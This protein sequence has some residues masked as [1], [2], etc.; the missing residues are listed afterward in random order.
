MYKPENS[1][2]VNAKDGIFFLQKTSNNDYLA[3]F[4]FSAANV[5][6]FQTDEIDNFRLGTE[7]HINGKNLSAIVL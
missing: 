7:V 4:R 6:H 1:V 2:A 5:N 3:R